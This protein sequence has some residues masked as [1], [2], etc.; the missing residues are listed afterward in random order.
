MK[1]RSFDSRIYIKEEWN[2]MT[3]KTLFDEQA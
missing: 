3:V 1:A 2:K